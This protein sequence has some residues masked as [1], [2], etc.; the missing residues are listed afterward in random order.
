MRLFS[1]VSS[2]LVYDFLRGFE[3]I[4]RWLDRGQ[5]SYTVAREL[6]LSLCSVCADVTGMGTRLLLLQQSLDV[7]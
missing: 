2:I 3:S 7:G 4:S 1:C 6:I 5:D